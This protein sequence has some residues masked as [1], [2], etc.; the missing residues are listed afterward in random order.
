MNTKIYKTSG[1]CAQVITFDYEDGKMYNLKFEGGCNGNLRAIGKLCEGKD[2]KEI[3]DILEGNVC[4][5]KPTS[6]AD[7]LSRAIRECL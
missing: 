6:C 3:A 4:N 1:T 2:M 7:Q 5:G